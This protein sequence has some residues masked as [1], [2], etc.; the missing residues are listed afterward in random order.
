M[1]L[2][3]AEYRYY[4]KQVYFNVS[5]PA[6]T[7]FP[8]RRN[9]GMVRIL[10]APG[11]CGLTSNGSISDLAGRSASTADRCNRVSTSMVML[12]GFYA[13]NQIRSRKG[14]A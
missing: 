7:R 10:C 6:F 2:T 12:N 8:P 3:S 14:T 5:R 1:C 13:V 11:L 4:T 9:T